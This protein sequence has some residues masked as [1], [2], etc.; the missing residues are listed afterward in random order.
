MFAPDYPILTDRLSLRPFTEEDF[1]AMYAIQSNPDVVRYLY[2]ETRD[3][4]ATWQLLKER[5]AMVRIDNEGDRLS[6][7]IVRRDTGDVIGQ[8]TLMFRSAEH[9]QGE[10]GYVLLPEHHGQGF[11]TEVAVALMELG[12]DGLRLHRLVGRCDGRN[13]AS[14]RVL[15]R[16]G[17]R[18]EAHLRENEFVKGEWT[19]E[20]IYALLASEWHASAR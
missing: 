8:A 12:F 2:G 11:A 4:D 7:A 16:A 6:L 10:I 19:D 3:R 5:I 14:A 13:A 20:L 17:M 1:D 9:N 18:R 15:E